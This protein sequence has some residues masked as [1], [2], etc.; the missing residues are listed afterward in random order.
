MMFFDALIVE[1]F[2]I[3]IRFEGN[4]GFSQLDL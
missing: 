4:F 3:L 1:K 2:L